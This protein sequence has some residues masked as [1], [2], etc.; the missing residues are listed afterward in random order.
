MS[1]RDKALDIAEYLR[2]NNLVGIE[3]GKEYY[4]VE[5]S[6]LGLALRGEGH[7]SLP[8]VSAAIYCYIARRFGL[9]AHPCGF[10][11]HVHVIVR[12]ETGRDLDGKPL[13]SGV[14]GLP[15]FMDPFRSTEE[16][17]VSDLQNQLNRLPVTLSHSSYLRESPTSEIV[18]RC[19]KN[20]LNSVLQTPHHRNA[21]IDLADVKYAALWACMLFA[22]GA[23]FG[24]P[25]VGGPQHQVAQLPIRRYFLSLM[26][27]FATNFPLDVHL[28]EQYIAPLF[29]GLPEYEPLLESVHAMKA[30]DQIPRQVRRRTAEHKGV[31]YEI[32][33]VF[34]HQ[35][36]NYMAVVTGWDTECDAEEVWMER[37]G[38]DRLQAGRH[39]SFYHVM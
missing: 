12:P 20:I 35:R 8:L 38:V 39:Q 28:I 27:H 11:F 31:K 23:D 30:G 6:F 1:P 9:N 33:E 22:D 16:T 29:H 36:Y 34:R 25:L 14:D 19:A 2:A 4:N 17:P 18:F 24:D 10:P 37:M 26:E 15:M 3:P 13:E 21:S 7:N 5:H 32:G